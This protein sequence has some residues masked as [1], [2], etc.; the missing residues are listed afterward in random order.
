VELTRSLAI[1]GHCSEIT[2]DQGLLGDLTPK[3][4]VDSPSGAP[5]GASQ[6]VQEAKQ[7]FLL[8]WSQ[9]ME[10]FRYFA[11]FAFVASNRVPQAD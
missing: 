5:R 9:P 6:R 2:E 4:D 1:G 3:C 8:G 11:G 10:P 7:I